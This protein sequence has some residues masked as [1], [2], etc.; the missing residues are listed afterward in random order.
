MKVTILHHTCPRKTLTL[1]RRN[2][3]FLIG[4]IQ[5]KSVRVVAKILFCKM[6]HKMIPNQCSAAVVELE[7]LCVLGGVFNW[8]WYLLNEL[9]DNAMQAQHKDTYKLYYY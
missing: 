6:L 5:D 8:S 2:I 9:I 3:T 4:P 7:D 1:S